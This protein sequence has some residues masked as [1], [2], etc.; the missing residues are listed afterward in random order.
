MKQIVIISILSL[1][2]S[3]LN[4]QVNG[5][6]DLDKRSRQIVTGLNSV[7]LM[8]PLPKAIKLSTGVTLQY[9]EQGD[10]KGKPVVLIHGY[11]DSWRSYELVMP[12][13]PSSYHVFAITLRGHG[14]S[15]KPMSGYDIKDF[16]DDIAAFI[17]ANDLGPTV[18]VGHSMGSLVAQS[19]AV[20]YPSLVS[21]LVLEGAA[22]NFNSN[23]IV[24]ELDS[25][26]AKLEDPISLEFATE[27]QMSTISK[28]VAASFMN[29]IIEESLKIPARIWK[30]AIAGFID[31]DFSNKFK[32]FNKPAL[33]I[34]GDKDVICPREQQTI[35][36]KS[37]RTSRLLI[38]E[39]IGHCPH[40]ELKEKYAEDLT[41]FL[42]AL[43]D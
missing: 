3:A 20:N 25:F 4:A 43:P 16:A 1:V 31:E 5:V 10:V 23:K 37:I 42:D 22:S 6:A 21:A 33:I 11:S 17:K 13:L 41:A 12:M 19:V 7:E 27:F 34:W 32:K 9:V 36:V 40:W 26:V 35:L 29:T 28:E 2:F 24:A 39:G 38:Y 15:E 14:D 8:Q 18:V 30:A